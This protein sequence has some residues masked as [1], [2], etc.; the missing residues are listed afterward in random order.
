MAG[1]GVALG[2]APFLAQLFWDWHLA[3]GIL[4]R[5]GVG[6]VVVLTCSS[7]FLPCRPSDSDVLRSRYRSTGASCP[8]PAGR[9]YDG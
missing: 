4:W 9:R 3:W 5:E 6:L 1:G 8:H 7:R 2:S